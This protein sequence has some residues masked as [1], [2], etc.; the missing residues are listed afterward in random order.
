MVAY[1]A[2]AGF[3]SK[4][5]DRADIGTAYWNSVVRMTACIRRFNESVSLLPYTLGDSSKLKKEAYFNPA[6][7]E[8]IQNHMVSMTPPEGRDMKYGIM[9]CIDMFHILSAYRVLYIS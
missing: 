5:N 6:W 3:F 9:C 7:V 4:G 1:R 8:M 2:L